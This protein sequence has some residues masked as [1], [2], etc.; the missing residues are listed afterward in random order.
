MA[1]TLPCCHVRRAAALGCA[2]AP[3]KGW[4]LHERI[5]DIHRRSG[6]SGLGRTLLRLAHLAEAAH[7][8]ER[9]QRLGPHDTHREDRL[10]NGL[11]EAPESSSAGSIATSAAAR[12][13][14]GR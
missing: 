1:L 6:Q 11:A 14:V 13:E 9:A 4:P 7:Q 12:R 5:L 3:G 8:F 10:A 2:G